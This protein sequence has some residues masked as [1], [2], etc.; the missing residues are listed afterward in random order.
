MTAAAPRLA[1]VPSEAA[2]KVHARLDGVTRVYP[3][4][5]GHGEVHALGPIS[6]DL[7]AG[8][9]FSVV[10]PSGCGKS[11]L[12]DVL[13]GLAVGA[14]MAAAAAKGGRRDAYT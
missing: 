11:T 3:P 14:A 2:P 10:G 5:A 4:R 1:A 9:F 7:R 12:L 8:E 13:A 6:F